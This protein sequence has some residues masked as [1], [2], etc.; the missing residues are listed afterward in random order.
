[1]KKYLIL[2]F[3]TFLFI[4]LCVAAHINR[5]PQTYALIIGISDY[6]NNSLG[7]LRF[8]ESD[9]LSFSDFLKSPS[10]GNIPEQ[11]IVTLTTK[12][13]SRKQILKSADEL[14]KKR[15]LEGD[16]VIFYF[17]G[18]GIEEAGDGY[19]M[20]FEGEKGD[21]LASGIPMDQIFKIINSSPAKLKSI[22]IDACHAGLFPKKAGVKAI[23][24]DG[25]AAT[26]LLINNFV[27]QSA[28]GLMAV[29]SSRG[30]EES[31][32]APDLKQGLFTHFLV[33]GLQGSADQEP[34]DGIVTAGELENYLSQQIQNYSGYAQHPTITGTFNSKFPLSI[35][36]PGLAL[37]SLIAATRSVNAPDQSLVPLQRSVSRPSAEQLSNGM[38]F[39]GNWAYGQAT[40][41][42]KLGYNAVMYSVR[43]PSNLVDR[44][45]LVADGE[46]VKTTRLIISRQSKVEDCHDLFANYTFCFRISENGVNKYAFIDRLIEVGK[47]IYFDLTPKNTIFSPGNGW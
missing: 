25:N 17:S 33:K 44:D 10:A 26:T 20:P 5:E 43:G 15:A 12:L 22:Y 3:I 21:A 30:N 7:K 4:N 11:N 39:D 13:A 31:I 27:K 32:E 38:K 47:N 19:L 46:A 28:P 37:S 42:N 24:G 36:D 34:S 41:I 45:V 9:A 40:F 29:L 1:M 16:V 2:I 18:H 8:A 14:F 23:S 35:K 6:Q